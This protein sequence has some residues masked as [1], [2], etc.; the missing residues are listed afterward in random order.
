VPK[1]RLGVALLVPPP[2]ADEIDGL[3]RALGDPALGRIPAHLTLVPPV[4]VREDRLSD[5]LERLRKAAA[6]TRPF[7]LALG[8]PTTFLPVNPVLYLKVGGDVDALVALRDRVFQEPLARTLT[9]PFV[10]HLTVADEATPERIDAALVA[11]ADFSATMDVDRVHLLEEG[12]GRV[13]API[14]DAVLGPPAVVGRGG[15][16]VELSSTDGI[17][18]ETAAFIQ[19]EWPDE[20]PHPL[21]VTARRDGRVVGVAQGRVRVR[22]DTAHLSLLMVAA[23]ERGTGVGSHLLAAFC[24]AVAQR[25]ARSATVRTAVGGPALAFYE[26]RGWRVE[27]G[28]PAHRDGV[29][30]VQLRRIFP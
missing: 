18:P 9:W 20:R 17:D 19:R 11:L 4:N 29:D 23:A 15:L 1:R 28:L 26:D 22:D 8:P 16:P 5:A 12:P 3:R 7:R 30:F 24:A 6:A 10:P 25:G 21:V 27:T 14:A 2:L 13:W